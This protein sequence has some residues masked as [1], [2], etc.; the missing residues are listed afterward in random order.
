MKRRI[1]LF[2][3]FGDLKGLPADGGHVSARRIW[4]NLEKIGYEVEIQNRIR[5]YGPRTIINKTKSVLGMFLDCVLWFFRLA[6][7]THKDSLAM[8]IGYGGVMAPLDYAIV[9]IASFLGY[10]T[11][12]YLKGGGT[13]KM[14]ENGNARN[15]HLFKMTL[16]NSNL[17]LTEGE[18]N[19]DL[20]N[21]VMDNQV[22]ICYMPNFIEKDFFPTECPK[23]PSN[24][25]NMLYFGRIDK[26]KNVKLIVEIFNLVAVKYTQATITIVGKQGTKYANEV[27][28]M[29][30]ASPF[31]NRIT[32]LGHSSHGELAKIMKDQ[33]VFIFPSNEEREGH[34]NSL[35]EAMAWGLV[36]V[37][38]NNNFLPSIVGDD[39]LVVKGY[40][41]NDY[42]KAI[43][44]LI[45]NY[46]IEQK[47][48][49]MYQRVRENFTQ[50]IVERKL[51]NTIEGIFK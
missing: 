15:K 10:K 3:T 7:K 36:P 13:D 34:S 18:V 41:I 25:I 23:K 29:I 1:Y 37:V 46:L 51:Y 12:Y 14:Y 17:V 8:V 45:D 21:R 38:S 48:R 6:T 28:S 22:K 11:A 50:D 32:R 2:G 33:H 39:D 16:R 26:S 44:M 31:K 35:N 27:D 43:S 19:I 40:N 47:S 4:H 5:A 24:G 9:S 42:V 49:Q 30:E 20:V